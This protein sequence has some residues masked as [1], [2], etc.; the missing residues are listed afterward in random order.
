MNKEHLI[1][2]DTETTGIEVLKD[3]LCQVCYRTPEGIFA[4]YF[5]PPVPMS[6]KSM[7][8]TNI[9]NKMLADKKPFSGSA[10]NKTLQ[11]LLS[12]GVLVAHNAKFDIAMLT[13]EGMTV[14]KSICT[15][16]IAR[17]LDPNNVIPEYNLPFLRY[18]YELE[19][20]D[21][22]AHDAQG[23]VKVLCA[24]FDK[25]F[26]RMKEEFPAFS[27]EE[28]IDRMIEISS[29]PSLYKIFNFGKYK[30]KKLEEVV[31]SDR[32]YLEWLLSQKMTDGGQDED[33]IYTLD[34]YLKN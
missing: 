10:M 14:P 32:R 6:V 20:P 11:E 12:K 9:T 4:E 17:Y 16:R 22:P 19:V 1:F 5:K 2:L 18:Y 29:K 7:S 24:V 21:A 31:K 13:A 3:R 27:E 30:D 23:D 26:E 8:I 28:L 34:Y 25:L 15:L 33:W